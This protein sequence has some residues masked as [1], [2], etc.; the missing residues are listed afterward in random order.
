ML[1]WVLSSV[2]SWKWTYVSEEHFSPLLRVEW[3]KKKNNLKQVA[4]RADCEAPR[5]VVF[6]VILFP[7]TILNEYPS[8][9]MNLVKNE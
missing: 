3:A 5:Y 9:V 8:R 2:V 1:G 6:E 7:D 4:R